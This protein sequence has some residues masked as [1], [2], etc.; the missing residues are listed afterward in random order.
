MHL[1]FN[2]KTLLVLTTI[3]AVMSVVARF[4][5]AG[6]LFLWLLVS[7]GFC[8]FVCLLFIV[9]HK[10]RSQPGQAKIQARREEILREEHAKIQIAKGQIEPTNAHSKQTVDVDGGQQCASPN[11]ALR[12]TKNNRT[13]SE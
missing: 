9:G 6:K 5:F 10:L 3:A 4:L 1:Q 8:L 11:R 12:L 2:I 13:L 7:Y